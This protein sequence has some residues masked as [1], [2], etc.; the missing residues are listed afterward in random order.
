MIKVNVT[1]TYR[2]EVKPPRVKEK[3]SR[4]DEPQ[5]GKVGAMVQRKL[6]KASDEAKLAQLRYKSD[7]RSPEVEK[8]RSMVTTIPADAN[9][10][11]P[12][13]EVND[14]DKE[15]RL[16]PFEK[17]Q[18]P[19]T[20]D[21]E[22]RSDGAAE[23]REDEPELQRTETRRAPVDQ[24][25]R[26]S[27]HKSVPLEGRQLKAEDDESAGKIDLAQ[28][29]QASRS[30]LEAFLEKMLKQS[31]SQR[32][33]AELII[34]HQAE[35]Q[36]DDTEEA[37]AEQADAQAI[38]RRA[39]ENSI[40]SQQEHAVG[41]ERMDDAMY[42][43]HKKVHQAYLEQ[44][45]ERVRGNQKAVESQDMMARLRQAG[46]SK[47]GVDATVDPLFDPPL[48]PSPL[49]LP[50][51]YARQLT[52]ALA[53]KEPA[54]TADV[55]SAPGIE[56]LQHEGVFGLSPTGRNLTV[57]DFIR[58]KEF[59]YDL[60]QRP[61]TVDAFLQETESAIFNTLNNG[62]SSSVTGSLLR[63]AEAVNSFRN[64]IIRSAEVPSESLQ[65]SESAETDHP[66][67]D[68]ER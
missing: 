64:H 20:H 29:Q 26:V 68:D 2:V 14:K 38:V 39:V 53:P 58:Q 36:S 65:S 19:Q 28:R 56:T 4:E 22:K 37:I 46:V 30:V 31:Q 54:K 41:R 32:A 44:L 49:V 3:H 10:F 33:E 61:F 59:E 8:R 1:N 55:A 9:E 35:L 40:T 15:A 17:K 6:E 63:A 60:D 52:E 5:F 12:A 24:S 11:T 67:Q 48:R 7:S 50:E 47:V 21:T 16:R 25:T 13:Y 23:L 45:D 34:E 51:D 18:P 66:W 27:E 57:T 62:N 43:V 42:A